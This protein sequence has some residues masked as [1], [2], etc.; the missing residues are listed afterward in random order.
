MSVDG[1][2]AESSTMK[3][4]R[5]KIFGFKTFAD[6]TEFDLDGNIISVIGPNGCGKS[7]I[8]DSILWGLGETNARNLRAQTAKEVI[9]SGSGVRKP[10]GYAEVSLLFDNE[11]GTLPIDAAE[12]SVTRR[13]TRAGDSSYAINKRGCRLRDVNDLLADSG[14]GKAG[15]AIVSQ[16]DIDQALSASAQQ[17]RA[18]IDE[19]AGVQRYRARRTESVRRLDHAEDHL[20]R[21][22]DIISEIEQQ[23]LPLEAEA[24]SAKR[25]K[26]V[27]SS[28]REVETGLL[29]KELAQAVQDLE[30]LEERIASAM[31][32]AEDEANRAVALEEEAKEL[33]AKA[34]QTEARIEL[35]R[36]SQ[37]RAQ[38]AYE[39]A[40]AAVQVAEHKLAHLDE[41]EKNLD[42]ESGLAKERLEQAE[43]ELAKA[44]EE[45][46][47]ERK[48]LEALREELSGAGDEAK[49]LSKELDAVE[50]EVSQA[51]RIQAE[52]QKMQ[53]E[54]EHRLTRIRQ[55]KVELQGIADTVPDLEEAVATAE[56]ETG[57]VKEKIE[58]AQEKVRQ[59]ENGLSELRKREE[60]RSQKTRQL[61]AQ[62]ASLDG[63]RKGIEAT[64]DAHEGLAQ[65]PRAVM[66]AV[67]QGM[68]SGEYVPVGE[69]VT[70]DPE[71]ATAIDTALGGAANDLIV[72]D[73]AHA[74]RAIQVLKENRLG[75]ATFQ[76][77]PLMR[78]VDKTMELRS[79]LVKNG[80]IGVASELVECD[81]RFRPVI[82][83]LLGRV[84]VVE[85]IDVALGLAKTRGWSRLVTLD[86]EVVFSSGAVSGGAKRQQGS[87][88]VQRKAEL[89]E[90]IEDL[91]DLQDKLAQYEDRNSEAARV[92]ALA[93]R[94]AA[95]EE[96]DGYS[97]E[98]EESRS[99][100]L[101]LRHELQTTMS[102]K[103]KLERE[104]EKLSAEEKVDGEEVDMDALE[105]KRDALMRK[106]AAKSSNAE[107]ATERLQEAE[108]RA[109]QSRTRL[110]EAE[111]RLGNLKQAEELRL[112]RAENLEPER[113]KYRAQIGES[114]E[115]VAVEEKKVS[116]LRQEVMEAIESRKAL[117]SESQAKME[118]ASTAR[119][120]SSATSDV[121]HKSEIKRARA[122]SKRSAAI[123]RLVDEYGILE[124]EALA[125]ADEVEVPE[126]AAVV[127][128]Q[129]RKELKAMGEVNLG[130]IDA[131]ERLNERH[132]ELFG[133]VEDIQGGM[134]EI[135][136]SIK[137]MDRLTRERF[138]STF[139][140]LRVAF[141]ETFVKVFGGGEGN[142]SLTEAENILDSGVEISVQIP[143]KRRQRLELLSGGER[144]MSAI[145]FL[146]A[147]LKIKPSPLVILDEVDAPLD[148]RNVERFVNL[149]REFNDMTQFILITHN[150][151]TIESADVWFGV[152]MQEPGVST[153]VPFKVPPKGPAQEAGK[154]VVSGEM[155]APAKG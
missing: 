37:S 19:A 64:I 44:Q 125:K 152:T 20:N 24:E 72:P 99:W 95:K 151:V 92:Q 51:R 74:K 118:E 15:Y 25:Y 68:I 153:L 140:K 29:M 132:Q 49:A 62:I 35:L 87:G 6:K 76:P 101:N 48:S 32:L 102:S 58:A 123:E 129:L 46:A 139:D 47:A 141:E 126:D 43:K 107:Q 130:A 26:T 115:L 81:G 11:D 31:K 9:F 143:G 30:E 120:A 100:L 55:V 111:G 54:H 36:E 138:V 116:E 56:S 86:G 103:E 70:V 108:N 3:L 5:V 148:G 79:V 59:A 7:N 80:V 142:L 8:V 17:R 34:S 137:E 41:T 97:G 121:L 50:E 105:A 73:E 10:Q 60:E 21:V 13:L 61:L 104:L 124:D 33:S 135:Q 113:E 106:L 12:V 109:L 16:S 14:L 63:K 22:R 71:F 90:V 147:L 40:V 112:R 134:E 117:L 136:A 150:P 131:F 110:S 77:I 133:Q 155:M 93:A 89:A 146:F 52:R 83:S 66:A 128:S 84:V 154:A 91:Q 45:E 78:P 18:W 53:L 1:A 94:Q 2:D 145:A 67:E 57:A 23:M 28:L 98:Y 149:M 122:D 4:K 82:D 42:E 75:R 96:I 27:Q 88:M 85:D 127:V 65:G 119:K 39:Q 69:A 38:A 144:A 114:K